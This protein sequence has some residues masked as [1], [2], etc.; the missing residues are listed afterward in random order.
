KV[1][2]EELLG[3]VQAG[4]LRVAPCLQEGGSVPQKHER[5]GVSAVVTTTCKSGHMFMMTSHSL[6]I[7]RAGSTYRAR[8]T[9]RARYGATAG[10][11]P[12][13]VL[14]ASAVSGNALASPTPQEDIGLQTLGGKEGTKLPVGMF[15]ANSLW[16]QLDSISEQG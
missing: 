3:T 2:A 14:A 4:Q 10:A 1:L 7:Y 5:R 8:K 11:S 9:P 6:E 12:M 13:T 16:K 15:I